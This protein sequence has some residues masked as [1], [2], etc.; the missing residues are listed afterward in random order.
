MRARLLRGKCAGGKKES[1]TMM[2]MLFVISDIL[3]I[4]YFCV[5]LILLSLN[6]GIPIAVQCLLL[7]EFCHLLKQ[8]NSAVI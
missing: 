8:L 2:K 5:S 3:E 7:D 1:G 4:V 6:S